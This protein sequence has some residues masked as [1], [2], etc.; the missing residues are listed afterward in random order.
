MAAQTTSGTLPAILQLRRLWY[1][2]GAALLLAVGLLSLLPVPDIVVGDKLSHLVTYALLGAWFSL[3]AA[4][5][6]A[7][8]AVFFGLLG[9]GALI[10]LLQGMTAYR[11]AEWADLLANGIGILLGL[12]FH[13]T[14]LRRLLLRIDALL[15]GLLLRR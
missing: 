9:Y 4:R 5:P 1:G 14:P 8:V 3:L 13:F 10:E 12:P 11:Y 2:C 6:G 15:A 7:L